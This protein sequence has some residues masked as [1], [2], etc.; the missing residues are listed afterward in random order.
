MYILG[1]KLLEY[2]KY[3]TLIELKLFEFLLFLEA[4]ITIHF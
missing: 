3:A 4:G 2:E 1:M